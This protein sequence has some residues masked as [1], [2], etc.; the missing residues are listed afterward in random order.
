MVGENF[1]IHLFQMPI[2]LETHYLHDFAMLRFGIYDILYINFENGLCWR[3]YGKYGVFFPKYGVN[4]GNM[5]NMG[6]MGN[7]GS[8]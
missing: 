6:I 3:K 2:L 7:M 1:K 5:G 8:V 4:M